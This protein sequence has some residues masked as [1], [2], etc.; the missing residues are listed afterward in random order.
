[1]DIRQG[2]KN[3]VNEAKQLPII[4]DVFFLGISRGGIY[5]TVKSICFNSICLFIT[6][7]LY[8]TDKQCSDFWPDNMMVLWIK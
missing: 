4:F 7:R 1:M 2:I 5:I 6:P 8:V 3:Y